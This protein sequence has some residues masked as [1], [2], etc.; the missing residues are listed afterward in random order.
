MAKRIVV[1]GAGFGGLSCVRGL[2]KSDV[3][4]TLIDKENHHLFQPL[5]YQ[6]ATAGLSPAD[7][8]WPARSVLR[9]QRN[10]SVL[11]ASVESVDTGSK[12]VV[13]SAGSTPY[14]VLVLATGATHS[15]FAHPEWERHCLGLKTL[16]DATTARSRILSAF[17]Q[18][19]AAPSEAE[20][21]AW[22]TLVIVGGG[23]TGVEMAGSLAELSRRTLED[24]FRS[25]D[26]RKAKI[27]LLELGPRLLTAFPEKLSQDALDSLQRLGVDV[28]LNEGVTEISEVGVT[29][30]SGSIPCRTVVWAAGVKASP[31]AV[32]LNAE[33]GPAGRVVVD[34][35]CRVVGHED[36]FAIGDTAFFPTEDGKGLPGVAQTAMQQGRY[37]AGQ[38]TRG[39]D[40]PFRYRDL[41]ILATIGRSSAVAK[42]GR[43]EFSGFFAWAVWIFIHLRSLLTVQSK[44]LVFVQ[45]AWAYLSY[46]RGARL[47]TRLDRD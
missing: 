36:V 3:H 13:H 20:R 12:T 46:S 22:L 14:D 23:P 41:G 8:A 31:A 35:H 1:I 29:V 32:W 30:P 17:E 33:P 7:I 9:S 45:W 47:I 28:R 38:A 24:D 40:A 19:E 39:G 27:V 37:V 10:V 34:D 16:N 15:F 42:I 6:V 11:M 4:V 44:I 43:S 21:D 26:P 18:A 2:S 5:L 25:I